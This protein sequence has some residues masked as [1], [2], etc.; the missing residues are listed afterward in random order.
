MY[1][2]TYSDTIPSTTEVSTMIGGGEGK[3]VEPPVTTRLCV[4]NT[5]ARGCISYSL[6]YFSRYLSC[7]DAAVAFLDANMVPPMR[8]A[9]CAGI[10]VY[11]QGIFFFRASKW[12]LV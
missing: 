3:M 9:V 10:V 2:V 6:L 7:D 8:A 12:G 4:C 11:M 1:K 5:G